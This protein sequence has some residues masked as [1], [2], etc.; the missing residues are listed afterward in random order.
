MRCCEFACQWSLVSEERAKKSRQIGLF[1]TAVGGGSELWFVAVLSQPGVDNDEKTR[2]LTG[3]ALVHSD[4]VFFP[5]LLESAVRDWL[6][7][8]L[9]SQGFVLLDERGVMKRRDG[10][11][12]EW[13][14]HV[15]VSGRKLLYGWSVRDSTWRPIT[16]QDVALG[17]TDECLI[18][19]LAHRGRFVGVAECDDDQVARVQSQWRQQFNLVTESR[20]LAKLLLENGTMTLA[21]LCFVYCRNLTTNPVRSVFHR[22]LL[23]ANQARARNSKTRRVGSS[24]NL[25]ENGVHQE[26]QDGA[27]KL[28]PSNGVVAAAAAAATVEERK[29]VSV[30]EALVAVAKK[31]TLN[32]DNVV[33]M[34]ICSDPLLMEPIDSSKTLR[35]LLLGQYQPLPDIGMGSVTSS[36]EMK[37]DKPVRTPRISKKR[38]RSLSNANGLTDVH[39]VQSVVELSVGVPGSQFRNQWMCRWSREYLWECRE[40][41]IAP[42]VVML[43]TLPDLGV[44]AIEPVWVAVDEPKL[45]AK[46]DTGAWVDVDMSAFCLWEKLRLCPV[47]P[48]KKVSFA[49]FCVE[50]QDRAMQSFFADLTSVW[51]LLSLGFLAPELPEN[52]VLDV[53]DVCDDESLGGR[54]VREMLKFFGRCGEEMNSSNASPMICFVV[55]PESSSKEELSMVLE[56]FNFGCFER[57]VILQVIP[58]RH[59]RL[60]S[61][62]NEMRHFVVELFSTV[63][64]YKMISCEPAFLLSHPFQV[65]RERG[66]FHVAFAVSS[67]GV[68]SIAAHDPSGEIWVTLQLPGQVSNEQR[69]AAVLE[70]ASRNLPD[71]GEW[72]L[73][74]L[75][76][77]VASR[78]LS[79]GPITPQV[80]GASAVVLCQARRHLV[81]SIGERGIANLTSEVTLVRNG[82]G[83]CW[84][85]IGATKHVVE[86]VAIMISSK[87]CLHLDF[88]VKNSE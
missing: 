29:M 73:I 52:A 60:P 32:E 85:L 18:G 54:F 61:P 58:E 23:F 19:G 43:D 14:L 17:V 7:W 44:G 16:P 10:G 78:C 88:V 76:C 67:F 56:T 5:S 51:T 9:A 13:Q 39:A 6:V 36:F 79:F 65:A 49:V 48:Q 46:W 64:I 37:T 40:S 62:I 41:S 34:Q 30:S 70:F 77:S 59:V 72:D 57:Q 80:S 25:L 24:Q 83:D 11:G 2:W 53:K 75:D 87:G 47:V 1:A 63:R 3:E 82:S 20:F 66:S 55:W 22:G 81:C 69:V 26:Q 12:G 45:R 50:G 15:I 27:V 4:A 68:L 42:L 35:H 33:W 31:D 8:K 86:D 38:A 74:L 21:P 71:V 84:C 28:E